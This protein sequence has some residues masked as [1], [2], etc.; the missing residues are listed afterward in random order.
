MMRRARL[1]ISGAVYHL[2]A[3][4]AMDGYVE[5]QARRTSLVHLSTYGSVLYV[6]H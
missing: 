3:A 4:Y 1:D 5:E 2:M 6:H